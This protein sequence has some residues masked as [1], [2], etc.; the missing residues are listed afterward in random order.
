MY[1]LDFLTKEAQE[2]FKK[3]F[4]DCEKTI[5]KDIY[6]YVEMK[7]HGFVFTDEIIQAIHDGIN[8]IASKSWNNPG[9]VDF[10]ISDLSLDDELHFFAELFWEDR[11]PE[12]FEDENGTL[13]S[14]RDQTVKA[15]K[16]A[17]NGFEVKGGWGDCAY[18][19]LK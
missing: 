17:I 16:K 5:E 13:W 18:I 2:E 1:T 6:K 12:C 9:G 19:L 4:G 3:L 8:A 10:F 14:T 11:D 15:I 7:S